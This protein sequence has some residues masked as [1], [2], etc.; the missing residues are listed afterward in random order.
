MNNEKTDELSSKILEKVKSA[1]QNVLV[2]K[3]YMD[4][5]RE[6]AYAAKAAEKRK[7]DEDAIALLKEGISAD[8]IARCIKL[9]LEHVKELAEQIEK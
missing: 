8:L 9:P 2:R 1:K 7:A 5:I 6:K 3:G 4:L